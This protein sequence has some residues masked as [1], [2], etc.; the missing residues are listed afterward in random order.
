MNV[1]ATTS[2]LPPPA[3]PSQHQIWPPSSWCF[4]IPFFCFQ[5]LSFYILTRSVVRLSTKA[6]YSLPSSLNLFMSYQAPS[7]AFQVSGC[8]LLCW[9]TTSPSSLPRVSTTSQKTTGLSP[10][11]TTHHSRY[12]RRVYPPS[13]CASPQRS[14]PPSKGLV[15]SLGAERTFGRRKASCPPLQRTTVSACRTAKHLRMPPHPTLGTRRM[16]LPQRR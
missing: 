8:L 13:P 6:D 14:S 10:S 1:P 9:K 11:L 2:I 16:L 5:I 4:Y 3:F 15:N 12:T 7:R